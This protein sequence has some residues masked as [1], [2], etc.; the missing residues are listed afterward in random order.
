MPTLEQIKSFV[1]QLPD[2]DEG[3]TYANLDMNKL[4]QIA[5]VV[6]QLYEGGRD[7]VLG[8]I[9]MLV[10][11]G[12][13]DNIKARFA[14]HLLAVRATRKGNEQA[15]NEFARAIASQIGGD[16]PKA[17]Q[18][19]LIE[20]LQL[21]GTKA[22]IETLGKALLDQELCDTA[23]RALT[24]IRDGAAEQLL[25]ALPKVQG[26]R[27]L[28]IINS[29]AVIRAERAAETF[30]QALSDPD[31]DVRIAAAWGIARIGDG[32]AFDTLLR[33]AEAHQRWERINQA[34]A[35]LA[36]AE[37]L[38]AAGKESDA[39]AIYAHLLKT[40]TDPSERHI[41]EAAERGLAAVKQLEKQS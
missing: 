8:L 36:L 12:A 33:C 26:R 3:G 25:S 16:R 6:S 38:V 20:Q 24:S 34:D 18:I 27:R 15:R 32:S 39:A 13:G 7:S 10:E 1:G 40:K 31:P 4:E 21:A 41:R 2:P 9:D 37:N 23:A 22:V 28:S 11:P 14:L 5:K 29:L 19:Y 35:C 17:I 30:K